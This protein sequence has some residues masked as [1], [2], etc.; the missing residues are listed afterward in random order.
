MKKILLIDGFNFIF[1]AYYSHQSLKTS[2]NIATGAL[3]GFTSMMLKI[4]SSKKFDYIAVVCDSGEKNFRHQIYPEYKSNRPSVPSELIQ[5]L[6]LIENATKALS[7]PIIKHTGFEADDIIATL[8]EISVKNG[9]DVEIISSDK[10]LMQIVNEN[11]K[12]YDP[13]KELIF[14]PKEVEEKFGV[15]PEKLT[16]LLSLMGDKSDNVPGVN[17]IGPKNAAKLI[18]FF[19]SLDNL[20]ENID[21]IQNEKQRNNIKNSI[22]DVIISN[23][24]I[25][26]RFDVPLKENIIEDLKQGKPDIEYINFFINKYE[27]VSL[28]PRFEKTLNCSLANKDNQNSGKVQIIK[29]T[30]ELQDVLI[31]ISEDSKVA[32]DFFALKKEP[33]GLLLGVFLTEEYYYIPI[34]FTDS[35]EFSFEEKTN[36]KISLKDV[37][38]NLLK[39]LQNKSILKISHDIKTIMHYAKKYLIEVVSYDDIKTMFY[40]VKSYTSDTSLNIICNTIIAKN[41]FMAIEE[42]EEL[43]QEQ[44]KTLQDFVNGFSSIFKIHS[45]LEY[46]LWQKSVCYIYEGIDKQ[47]LKILF[48]MEY[49]GVM[50]DKIHLNNL[51]E[52]FQKD[53]EI[54]KEKIYRLAGREFN[55]NSTKQLNEI[56]FDEMGI[57]HKGK[58]KKSTVYSTDSIVLESLEDEG[59]EIARDILQWRHVN[60][61]VNTYIVPFLE[62]ADI[63]NRI[64]TNYLINGTITGRLSSS[65]PN[66]QNI[67]IRTD[68]GKKIRAAFIVPKGKVL[69]SADYSQIELRILAHYANIEDLIDAF[70]KGMDIHNITASG[71]F[72]VPQKEVDES[73]RRQAKIINF[74]IIYGISPFG[75][76]K[77]LGCSQQEA[78][79]YIQK[80]FH[81]YEGIKEYMQKTKEYAK[82]NGFV[83][84]IYGRYCFL[85]NINSPNPNIRA[86]AERTAINAP[87]QG[88]AADIMKIAMIRVFNLLKQ[89]NLKS[90]IIMQIHD[91]LVLEC[92]EEEVDS[93]YKI[94]KIGMTDVF[95]LRTPLVIDIKS[96]KN[97]HDIH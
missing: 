53:I 95:T 55:I 78:E 33:I 96:G 46:M 15:P 97:W 25:K 89:N 69:I 67:P 27:F 20:I 2:D 3:Y 81:R 87:I 11:I 35:N 30:K 90:K 71:V 4:L 57:A 43:N 88:S 77:Q 54:L 82:T 79:K 23:K 61:I 24:L 16:D 65:E 18:N 80:Y 12:M 19:S 44:Q 42:I 94:L 58:S 51:L 34:N 62:K 92:P 83:R 74:G 75:L 5:Q 17:G 52:S 40:A 26:L 86:Y 70:K 7:V 41:N 10:D 13:M 76:K 63:Q 6:L 21:L 1:R 93:V 48:D 56:L 66:L 8:S 36:K 37:F 59:I 85:P 14:G 50:V 68:D 28:I 72:G 49:C 84:T 60:K 31:K 32:I 38:S 9:I 29:N 91:E 64:H 45:K 22:R 47:L 39:T 73:M